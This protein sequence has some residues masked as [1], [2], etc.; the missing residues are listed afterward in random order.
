MMTKNL[1]WKAKE[2]TARRQLDGGIC[3]RASGVLLP[4]YAWQGLPPRAP[5]GDL[6]RLFASCELHQKLHDQESSILSDSGQRWRKYP[7]ILNFDLWTS[8]MPAN[9]NSWYVSYQKA[10]GTGMKIAAN[11]HEAIEVACV[12][13]GKGVDVQAVGP[14]IELPDGQVISTAE[15]RKLYNMRLA[16]WYRQTAEKAENPS[17]WEKRLRAAEDLEM[18]FLDNSLQP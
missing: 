13:L 12:M 15:I 10:N 9:R 17:I 8:V 5:A 16:A 1:E 3:G 18:K 6:L 11:R 4:Q 14:M 2:A 7:P